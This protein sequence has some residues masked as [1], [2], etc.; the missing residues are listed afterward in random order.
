MAIE[1][2]LRSA[3]RRFALQFWFAACVALVATAAAKEPAPRRYGL[4]APPLEI[5]D[6]L[7]ELQ[8]G[9]V[10]RLPAEERALLVK[11]WE[12]HPKPGDAAPGDAVKTDQELLLE[13]M[14]SASGVEEPAARKEC[15]DRFHKLVKEAGDA[16]KDTKDARERGEK[17]MQFLHAGVMQKGYEEEQTT[18]AAVFDTGEYNCVSSSAM[19][20]LAGTSLG[21]K[22]QP[23]SIPGSQFVA[24]HASLDLVDGGE[25]IQVE[26]TN[27]DGFDWQTKVNRPGVIVIG[28]VPDRDDAH[29]VDGWG[30]A[31]MIYSNRGTAFSKA[32]PPSRLAAARCYLAA[33]ACDPPDESATNNLLSIFTN[34]GLELTEGKQFEES[35]RV[36]A[37]GLTIA[38]GHESLQQNQS[39]A[40][41]EY[42]DS[43]LEAGDDDRAMGL[44]GRAAEATEDKDLDHASD[45]FIRFGDKRRKDDWEAALSVAERGL[46]AVPESEREALLEWRSGVFRQRS[47]WLLEEEQGPDAEGSLQVLARAYA[48]DPRDE[49]II[50][51]I[52]YHTQQ[53]LSLLEKK[54]G[55][56]GMSEHYAALR[57]QF[58]KVEEIPEMGRSHA[59]RAIKAL[60]DDE[61]FAEAVAAVDVYRPLYTDAAVRDELGG[62]AYDLWAEHLADQKQWRP[63][64]EKCA[65]GLRAF[66]KQDATVQRLRV[67]VD[68][69]AEPAIDAKKWDE[70][71]RIYDVGLEYAKGDE[72]LLQ[73]RKFC[74][75]RK[76]E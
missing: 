12:L 34:W 74:E 70:A 28:L 68:D 25:R 71:I 43:A 31:A 26:P 52:A 58:P 63:A 51:G 14:L 17:L 5:Y 16:V 38:P 42:I 10:P 9:E 2:P 62:V 67:T 47:Q 29:D 57:K 19:Y 37:F 72:H 35:L 53:A 11:I 3:P 6:R 65:E 30:L 60:A 20:F 24:G 21:L 48:L 40:W 4:T 69:W 1:F 13:A 36:L 15:R 59:L 32:E 8:L 45:A 54:S 33:L 41:S 7:A 18:F 55:V 75:G 22:L 49:E 73:N 56:K 27:P 76:G 64:L 39:H 23:V 66:P 50:A 61:K 46:K 44:V